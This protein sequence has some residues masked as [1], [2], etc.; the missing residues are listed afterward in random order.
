MMIVLANIVT[1]LI[2]LRVG[3]FLFLDWKQNGI[4][5]TPGELRKAILAGLIYIKQGRYVQYLR[6]NSSILLGTQLNYKFVNFNSLSR[7]CSGPK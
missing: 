6:S 1:H 2:N 4:N 7:K 3:D 5:D